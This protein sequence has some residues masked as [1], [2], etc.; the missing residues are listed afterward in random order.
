MKFIK[1]TSL[2][3]NERFVDSEKI[4]DLGAAK[5]YYDPVTGNIRNFLPDIRNAMV[6]EMD[7]KI[8][9]KNQQI[10]HVKNSNRKEEEKARVKEL[11]RLTADRKKMLQGLPPGDEYPDLK[12][13]W[14]RLEEEIE[15]WKQRELDCSFINLNTNNGTYCVYVREPLQEILKLLS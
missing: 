11:E 1:L 8:F 7:R 3:G 2:D 5:I 12:E 9:V 6:N 14:G 10:N 15:E 13:K 4:L